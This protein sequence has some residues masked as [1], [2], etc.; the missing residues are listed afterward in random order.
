[1]LLY[2]LVATMGTTNCNTI[3]V[4]NPTELLYIAGPCV[5]ARVFVN[6]GFPGHEVRVEY[7]LSQKL[8][9]GQ[10]APVTF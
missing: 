9:N 6:M 2:Q 3:N 4:F 5:H 10:Y 8:R 1:M 7:F